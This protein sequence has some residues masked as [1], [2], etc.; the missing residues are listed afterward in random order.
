LALILAPLIIL[1]D[2]PI[3]NLDTKNTGIVFDILQD[4][5]H[6]QN[7]TIIAVTHDLDFAKSSDRTIEMMD[8]RI[9]N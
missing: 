7:Q 2:E 3:G 8:G 1:G 4:L 5:P 6:N 9:I